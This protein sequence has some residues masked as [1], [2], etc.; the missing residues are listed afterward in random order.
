V[1]TRDLVSVRDL[2]L[3]QALARDLVSIDAVDF[4]SGQLGNRAHEIASDTAAAVGRSLGLDLTR[5]QPLRKHIL[6]RRWISPDVAQKLSSRANR[7]DVS[8]CVVLV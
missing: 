1:S 4:V 3:V 7:P 8:L 6:N 5:D 2:A